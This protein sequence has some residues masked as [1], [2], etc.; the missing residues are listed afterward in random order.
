MLIA[1]TL[2]NHHYTPDVVEINRVRFAV[3]QSENLDNFVIDSFYDFTVVDSSGAVLFS[4][5]ATTTIPLEQRINL[6]IANTDVVL[7]F[8]N[9]KIIFYTG[10]L[11][12]GSIALALVAI[13]VPLSVLLILTILFYYFLSVSL[14]KPFKKLKNFAGEI[15]MG[16]LDTALP[17]DK[18]NLF[19]EFSE[20]FDIMR[21]ELK[22]SR[23]RLINEEKSKKEL[24]ATLSHDIKTPVAIVRAASEL[25]EINETNAK[26]LAH[27]KAIQEKSRELDTLITDLFTSSL[28]DLSE[29]KIN[30]TDISVM[31]IKELVLA[32]DA[33]KKA[34]IDG[35]VQDCLIKA[36]P[37]R[38]SQ[39]FGNII[40]N[41][42][43]YAG[44]DIQVSFALENN[45]LSISFK[46]SGTSLEKE[47]LPLLTQKFYRGKNA[48]GLQG[49]GLGL[50]ICEKLIHKMGGELLV[51]QENNGFMV[52]LKLALS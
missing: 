20:S 30:I 17:M 46:D 52:Q 24:I 23:Q 44:S 5:V 6:A 33:L 45:F 50:Y 2:N 27:I 4:T 16:N 36:D 32:A 34:K 43:K 29:L 1:T 3:E 31:Q 38:L 11:L 15:A 41:S 19:G 40:S 42:Y 7:N 51:K 39:V 9:G 8:Y 35:S 12:T 26:K 25:L 21:E 49:A 48:Q 47:E 28:E 10:R 13:I 22:A 18:D 14:Y 37:L